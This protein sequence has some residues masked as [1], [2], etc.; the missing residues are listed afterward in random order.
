M[1]KK[2]LQTIL[3]SYKIKLIV[4]DIEKSIF[5]T[6]YNL[7]PV[8]G[9]KLN[10]I[11]NNIDTLQLFFDGSIILDVDTNRMAIKEATK[12]RPKTN[13]F[14]LCNSAYSGE[15]PLLFGIDDNGKPLYFDLVKA[16]H[17]LIAGTTGSGKSVF[18]H[19]LIL[20]LLRLNNST[21]V[22]IDVK[23]VE[24]SIYNGCYQV[25][26]NCNVV[27]DPMQA[28]NILLDV[29]RVMDS[30]YKK[31]ER[32]HVR[33]F[34]EYQQLTNDKY[35]I[36]VIDELADLML[37]KEV[38]KQVENSICRIAQLG[39]A[40]GIHIITATQR[41]DTSVITGL[42]KANIPSRVAFSVSSKIDS[43]II[44]N[45]S[46]AEK[47]QGCGDGLL[48]PIGHEKPLHF[49]SANNDTND[50]LNYV[51]RYKARTVK[52]VNP[53]KRFRLFK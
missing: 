9:F 28:N 6:I 37:N 15:L 41:P 48:L 36:V 50:I 30:R 34:K 35:M 26:N 32:L 43:R 40:C 29:C 18:M 3:D 21:M 27:C 20:S 2:K 33:T 51:S 8:P 31:M 11:K 4:K 22:L 10:T 5:Y 38:K 49:Q 39:R 7:E 52:H 47:L 16:P 53:V 1:D 13:Y 23:R 44:I 25:E 14:D 12:N 46:G 19:N 45:Q 42:I 17:L 24:L